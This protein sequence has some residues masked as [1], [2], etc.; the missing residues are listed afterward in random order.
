[1]AG[2][3]ALKVSRI[4]TKGLYLDG[5]GLYLQVTATGQKSWIFRFRLG[6]RKTPRD[7]GLG[8]LANVSLAQAREKAR[9][10][11]KLLSDG[12]DPIEAKREAQTRAALE[13]A[14]AITFE[15]AAK[16]YI[17]AHSPSWRNP[18]HREQWPNTL[19]DYVYPVI[20]G[21]PVSAVNVTHI[22]RILEL[23][24][25][26]KP[27]T[28][29]RVRGRI[30]AILD[31]A[32]ARGYRTGENPARWRGHIENLLPRRS[33]V[34]SVKHHPALPYADMGAFMVAL[35][36]QDGMAALALQFLILT[37]ARTSETLGAR[38][39][40][41]DMG[42]ATWTIPA[43]RIKA[44]REHRIPLSAPA[45]AILR[46][47]SEKRVGDLVFPGG[48]RN[49]PLSSNAILALLKR[50]GHSEITAHG[51]R[52]TFRDWCSEQTNYP[53]DVAEMA[54]AHAIGDKVEAAYRRGDLIEKRM[55][56]MK[57]WAAYCNTLPRTAKGQNVVAMH[58]I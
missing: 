22:V 24:W 56:L 15:D 7:M 47:M 17:A 40:E 30:E 19:R 25:T 3:T 38:W 28:A 1:M 46:Q 53:R 2:L 5:G 18:K 43:D 48:R 26:S 34:Q 55:R 10:A 33:K 37:V 44:G 8:A 21:L 14:S 49:R 51:F 35:R 32:T 23:I 27:E 58:G 12:I 45:M 6:G 41:I 57:D 4:K 39:Q 31:W 9:E 50:M 42:A 20:G 36:A 52:S 54:L 16:A 11:R 13:K 29:S